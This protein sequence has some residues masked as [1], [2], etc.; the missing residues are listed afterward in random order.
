MDFAQDESMADVLQKLSKT[1]SVYLSGFTFEAWKSALLVS[2]NW[3]LTP[4]R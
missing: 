2:P 1:D 4:P 3:E